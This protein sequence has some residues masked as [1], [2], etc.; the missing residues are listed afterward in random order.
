MTTY[1]VHGKTRSAKHNSGR[2]T[3]LQVRDRRVLTRIVTSKK[4]PT[5]EKFTT[6]LN[7]HLNTQVSS[8]TV[9]REL[10]KMG[11]HGRVAIP[12]PLITHK[13]AQRGHAWCNAH[14]NWTLEDTTCRVVRRVTLYPLT[15]HW[16][17]VCLPSSIRCGLFPSNCR[18]YWRL[19]YSL[20]H[21]IIVFV[22]P[23]CH[24]TRFGHS[25][26]G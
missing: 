10:H 4:K 18:T 26:S 22:N 23:P 12:K 15:H 1:T 20:G 6:E 16:T 24:I 3:K 21:Y 5:A 19:Y 11:I 14:K 13:N 2:K 17:R 9:R 7:L 8:N 25:N